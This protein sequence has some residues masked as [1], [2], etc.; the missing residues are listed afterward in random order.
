[1]VRF[2]ASLSFLSTNTNLFNDISEL[3]ANTAV[4]EE[5]PDRNGV[6]HVLVNL[7]SL[8][9]KSKGKHHRHTLRAVPKATSDLIKQMQMGECWFSSRVNLALRV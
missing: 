7:G 5:A 9:W 8:G 1:M 2:F 6:P 4:I 3:D